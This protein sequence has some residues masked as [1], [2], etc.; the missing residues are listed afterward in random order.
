MMYKKIFL[1]VVLLPLIFFVTRGETVD[2][3][4]AYQVRQDTIEIVI[5]KAKVLVTDDF[6]DTPPAYL[7][8]KK[9]V[10]LISVGDIMAHTLQF[11]AAR[12]E[13]GYDFYPQFEYIADTISKRDIAIAN[14]ETV[15][16]GE[17]KRYS[18]ANMIFNAPDNLAESIKRAGFDVLTTANNHSL[19]RSYYGIKRTL[20]VLDDLG[21]SSTGTYRTEEESQTILVKEVNG[22]S[23]AFLSYSYSTNGW[24]IPQEH[25]YAINMIDQEKIIY[26]IHKAKALADFV[27]VGV[28]WG[29][30]YHLNENHHQ[31]DLA[32]LMFY[33]GAD[34]ILGT[35]PH[36]L[37][38]FEHV[39][40]V[41]ISGDKKDKFII[42]SQG[43]FLSG[44]R[45]YP[46]AIGMYI[47]YEFTQVGLGNPYVS[48]VAVMPTYVEATSDG[49]HIL[50]TLND[51]A[52]SHKTSAETLETYRKTFIEHV[53]S[54]VEMEPYLND[55]R[56]YVIYENK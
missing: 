17:D 51:Q 24:P 38:P 32:D 11:N 22:I 8:E 1:I 13:K 47:T 23:F 43:N 44:Q 53:S 30:E 7:N 33:E 41:D 52:I 56:A 42:Y 25:P 29:L 4:E 15:F 31:R 10:T 21:I 2:L 35:H 50:D 28:H 5:P 55:D 18:G 3:R 16:A 48:E 40:M 20:D 6:I 34:I 14:L 12:T 45:T 39:E 9:Q 27:V 49:V 37:Q 19:D 36:V 54:R 46:R 26:D